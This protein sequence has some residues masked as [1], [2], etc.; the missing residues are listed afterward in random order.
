MT[1]KDENGD[2]MESG[3]LPAD[4]LNARI[5]VL[6][7]REVEARILAPVIHAL[8]DEFG[9]DQVLDIV[10]E[11]LTRVAAD[12][13]AELARLMGGNSLQHFADSLQYWTK[14]N[15]LE[16]EVVEQTDASFVFNV[17]RCRYADLYERLG[18]SGYGTVFSCARDFALIKGFNEKIA[19][20][21]T[22]TIME[23]ASHC[24]FHYTFKKGN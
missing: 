13:G 1:E 15:A 9:H 18:V 14:D 12:Q 3:K 10:R 4:D 17:T 22:Q 2:N 6:T 16:L 19:L 20:K 24:D 5:G 8:G 23:G 21:R 11:T 7:R